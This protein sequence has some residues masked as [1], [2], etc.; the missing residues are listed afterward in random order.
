MKSADIFVNSTALPTEGFPMTIAEAAFSGCLLISS[1]GIWLNEVFEKGEDGFSYEVNDH[2]ELSDKI[3][4]AL[5]R[6]DLSQKMAESFQS[7]AKELF[8][9]NNFTENHK[10]VYQECLKKNY[11]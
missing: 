9:I 7:K 2:I 6:K 1:K 3:L 5:E 8:S 10:F 4:I 11:T